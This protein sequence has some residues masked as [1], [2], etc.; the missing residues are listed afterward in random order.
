MGFFITDNL[1]DIVEINQKAKQIFGWLW[2]ES[3]SLKATKLNWKIIRNDGID[4]PKNEYPWVVASREKRTVENLEMGVT[5]DFQE[6]IWLSVT[7][8]AISSFTDRIF[9]AYVDITKWKKVEK[10]LQNSEIKYRALMQ[11]A[12]EAILIANLQ[13]KIIEA[14]YK[15]TEILGY[16]REELV[17]M[18]TNQIHPPEAQQKVITAILETAKKGK[19]F[20]P[21]ILALRKDG[22]WFWV[23]IIYKIIQLDQDEKL[24]QV[25]LQDIT[26][27]VINE[28]ALRDSEERFRAIFEQSVLGIFL[29]TLSG[30]IFRINQA[31]TDIL[32]YSHADLSNCNFVDILEPEQRQDYEINLR[33]I[34]GEKILNFATENRLINKNGRFIWSSLTVSLIKISEEKKY[35]IGLIENISQRKQIELDLKKSEERWQLALRGNNDGIWDCNITTNE[36]FYSPRCQEILGYTETDIFHHLDDWK[37]RMHPDDI[38]L[39]TESLQQHL[40]GQKPYFIAEYRIRCK[41]NTY[42]W[43]LDRGQAVWDE[44]GNPL[45]IVGSHTDITE[46]KKAEESLRRQT[47]QEQLIR[48]IIERIRQ[49]LN[50]SEILQTTV[51]EV[52]NILQVKGVI[53]QRKISDKLVIVL[54]ESLAIGKPSMLDWQINDYIITTQEFRQ[55]KKT[56]QVIVIEDIEESKRRLCSNYLLD[57]FDIKACLIMPIFIQKSTINHSQKISLFPREQS[58]SDDPLWGIL[59]AHHFSN[60]RQWQEWEINLLEQLRIQLEIAIQ[61]S[62]LYQQ[63]Q[64]SNEKL[65]QLATLDGLT[66]IANRRYFNEYLEQEWLRMAREK[67]PLSLIMCDIDFFKKYNDTYGHQK[68]DECLQRVAKTISAVVKRPADL[69]ARYGGEELAVILPNTNLEGAIYIAKIIRQAI[70]NL[71]IPHQSAPIYKQ[72]TMSLGVSSIIPFPEATS[73]SLIAGADQALYQAKEKG[74]NQVLSYVGDIIIS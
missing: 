25:I 28:T 60:Q 13:G 1:G 19:K 16:Q 40:T 54:A 46:R 71:E 55:E 51:D 31:F 48:K 20:I 43:I 29:A 56:E 66:Q 4:M 63:L 5:K 50:L 27:Y 36:C 8:T 14:N 45:R 59:V 3:E 39:V 12:G 74:R 62:K 22:N 57:F 34:I 6:V 33:S 47:Q 52:R 11:D 72:V 30:E 37:N 10:K 32:G 17:Q 42:K 67:K 70:Y 73:K 23:N 49:S 24:Y 65:Y 64:N 44:A 68:G 26:P 7:S 35:L 15:A 18:H 38:N 58:T 53:I 9:T 61:Q 41:D 2:E 21:N 69:V